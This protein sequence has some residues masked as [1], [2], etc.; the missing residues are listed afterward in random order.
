MGGLEF[1]EILL[2]HAPAAASPEGARSYLVPSRLHPASFT[3]CRQAAADVQAAAD[4][5]WL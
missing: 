1:D 3:P 2:D 4:G 5:L